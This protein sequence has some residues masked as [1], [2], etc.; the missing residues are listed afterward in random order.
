M[1]FKPLFFV[2]LGF[3]FLSF[4]QA[5]E[6]GDQCTQRQ[7]KGYYL[8]S[9][10]CMAEVL[11]CYFGKLVKSDGVDSP[12]D[13]EKCPGFHRPTCST[14]MTMELKIDG[15]QSTIEVMNIL[16][17]L[18]QSFFDIDM[19]FITDMHGKI[20]P[21]WLIKISAKPWFE[22][23]VNWHNPDMYKITREEFRIG[24][25]ERFP[26]LSSITTCGGTGEQNPSV[27]GSN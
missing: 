11:S 4:A 3:F 27:I 19:Q 10:Y 18:S 13:P 12:A 25:Q 9:G 23:R 8:K 20:D 2:L 21:P 14:P 17:K 15:S 6:V 24:L 5:A 7:I 16:N 22:R 1:K 26:N